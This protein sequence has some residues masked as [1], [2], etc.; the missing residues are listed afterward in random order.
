MGGTMKGEFVFGEFRLDVV[1]AQLWR[2]RAPI[3]LSAKNFEVLRHLIERAG[4]LVTKSDLLDAAWSD[5]HVG[6]SSVSV[7]M[8]AVRMALGDDAKAPRY[9]K[10]VARRGY[11]FIAAVTIPS[12]SESRQNVAATPAPFHSLIA[13]PPKLVSAPPPTSNWI[14]FFLVGARE[15]ISTFNGPL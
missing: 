11:R 2:G 4:E 1:G 7:A 12:P 8:S 9:I 3:A 13:L 14:F 5:L 15:Q 6:E 10:T